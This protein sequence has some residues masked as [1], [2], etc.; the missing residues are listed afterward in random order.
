MPSWS[1]HL[2]IA[3]EANKKLKLNKDLFYY[4]NLIPDVDKGT[5]ISRYDAHFYD[6]IPFPKCPK[7]NMINIDKFLSTYK[8][9]LDNSLILGY[10]SHILI[11]NFFNNIVY[12]NCWIQNSNNDIIGIKL[13]NGKIK[14]I[15]INDTKKIRRK[16]KHK[17]FE[18]Y[19]KYLYQDNKVELPTN[20]N[21][22]LSNIS[23]LKPNFLNEELVTKRFNYLENNFKTFNKLNLFERIFKHKYLLFSKEE[24]DNIYNNCIKLIIDEINKLE[25]KNKDK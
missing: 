8:D 24:L 15:D 7:E 2:A 16:Y 1:I 23:E 10:Y 11:D 5:S 6:N 4:G 21:I 17:D 19:G 9:N 18:L 3:K 20:K 14:H 25:L 12:S 22:I 13:K